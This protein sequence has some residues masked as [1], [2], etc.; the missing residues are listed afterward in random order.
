MF[1]WWQRLQ[2]D[3][4]VGWLCLLWFFQEALNVS[5][6]RVGLFSSFCM[7]SSRAPSAACASWDLR[8]RKRRGKERGLAPVFGAIR[9]VMFCK[10][11][12]W[13]FVTWNV[14]SVV[15]QSWWT[16]HS[17]KYRWLIYTRA[18]S[19]LSISKIPT[20]WGWWCWVEQLEL[21]RYTHAYGSPPVTIRWSQ[22]HIAGMQMLFLHKPG[23]VIGV[24]YAWSYLLGD[25]LVPKVTP[26]LQLWHLTPL[27][28]YKCVLGH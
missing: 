22:E 10:D 6:Y 19:C 25:Q 16:T 20:P 17:V 2:A 4:G 3:F 13:V 12:M 27:H 8:T 23:C 5:G 14:F 9:V 15:L 7:Q 28:T 24:D 21:H 1:S 11:R 18:L 26:Q